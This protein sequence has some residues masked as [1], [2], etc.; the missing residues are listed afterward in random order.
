MSNKST[1][2]IA[3]WL[4]ALLFF[5]SSSIL[6]ADS[7][8]K[9]SRNVSFEENK[10]QVMNQ[11]REH[12]PDVLFSGTTEGMTFHITRK[13]I[14][15]QLAR[16][17]SWTEDL[18]RKGRME[19]RRD[20]A[21]QLIPDQMSIYRTDIEW[22]NVNPYFTIE[23]GEPLNGFAN[24]YN[25]PDGASAALHVKQ[26]KHI[27]LKNIWEGVDLVYYSKNGHL[28][29]DWMVHNPEDYQKIAFEIKGADVQVKERNQLI[30]RTPFGEIQEGKLIAFQGKN[31]VPCSWLLEGNKVRLHV[32]DFNPAL[33]L[34]I[35]PPVRVWG[36]YWGGS[37][38]DRVTDLVSDATGNLFYTGFTM[39]L[40]NIAT[41][42]THQTEI[43]GGGQ[44]AYIA[45]FNA[46]G[47]RAWVSYFGGEMNESGQGC[48]LDGIGHVIIT[49]ETR[50]TTGIA[51]S[52]IYQEDFAGE[53]D[54][55]VAK[56]NIAAGALVWSSYYGGAAY[57]IAWGVTTDVFGN[58]YLAGITLSTS[59]I[60][61]SSAHQTAYGGGTCD[62][63]IAKFSL[64]GLLL[65]SGYYGGSEYDEAYAVATD[66]T[67]NV[68][69]TGFTYSE[70]Q[71]ATAGSHQAAFSGQNDVF[72]VKFDA[73]GQ[74]QWGTYIGG[75]NFE[76]AF[77]CAVDANNHIY[78]AGGSASTQG[79]AT[80]GTHQTTFNNQR[81]AFLMKFD[82]AG[83]RIW[84]TYYGG[85]KYDE[86]WRIAINHQGF[87]YAGG[88]TNSTEGIASAGVFQESITGT[89]D[90]GFLVK[91][92][93]NTGQRK[94]G[95]Y[96]GGANYDDLYG[97][98]TDNSFN[99]YIG[100]G[101]QSFSGIATPGS[102]QEEIASSSDGYLAK[103][104]DQEDTPSNVNQLLQTDEWTV[105]P[106]PARDYIQVSGIKAGFSIRLFDISG[107]EVYHSLVSTV[108]EIIRATNLP[109]GVYLLQVEQEEKYF[110][111]R[112]VVSK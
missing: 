68:Y 41:E 46:D 28:E 11:N 30:I 70:N 58:I 25:V 27:T 75:E 78:V 98:A 104:F 64:N 81:D 85:E 112:I 8:F 92:D 72:L 5:S 99:V 19:Q 79:I 17:N 47:T 12:R 29:S 37:A 9:P 50:S 40:A 94:W 110:K 83:N 61:T 111:K 67:G 33:P 22:L 100:G 26:Y 101:T 88:Q 39:S 106:N 86:F 7:Y 96:Y 77:A 24:Y 2:R 1:L 73:A 21:K 18:T 76:E 10:G 56:F 91:F 90:D 97:L 14:S 80:V 48:V 103:I 107:K 84:G 49:G 3:G 95:S 59:G 82:G 62:A 31:T 66:A 65:W 43:G 32:Q 87:I 34:T 20:E 63:F 55:F 71:I 52:G 57:E 102:F 38:P 16:V 93:P 60:A 89:S 53:F 15:Y 4:S 6:R 44:D 35:D 105:F 13:G 36:T 51:T 108:S 109:A 74:R 23:Y 54:A 69:L 42:G 45:R